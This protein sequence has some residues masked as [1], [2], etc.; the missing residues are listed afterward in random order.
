MNERT[1]NI[2]F[3]IYLNRS[4]STFLANQLSFHPDLAVAPEGHRALRRLLGQIGSRKSLALRMDRLV[5][6]VVEDEK[7]LS[8]GIGPDQLGKRLK[9]AKDE[10]DALYAVCDAFADT[11]RPNARTVIVKGY[12]FQELIMRHGFGALQ[13]GRKVQ[14]IFLM[15]D[16]RAMFASQRQSLSTN[17]NAPMQDNPIA[18]ALR[19]RQAATKA[20]IISNTPYGATVRY[21]D[22]VTRNETTL[23]E[24]ADFLALDSCPL[25]TSTVG[26]GTLAELIPEKQRDLHTNIDRPPQNDRINAW[27][28]IL[29]DDEKRVIEL[30]SSERMKNYNYVKAGSRRITLRDIYLTLRFSLR[31]GNRRCKI[32]R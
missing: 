32:L 19:W 21:E 16:P 5:R 8:W 28:H 2:L 13:R 9:D 17:S 7:L 18:A 30:V 24:I 22:L 23:C 3:L 11:H 27:T 4:G 6:D 15:R 31:T 10:I 14:A 12:F 29:T 20:Q 1:R 25:L 26:G